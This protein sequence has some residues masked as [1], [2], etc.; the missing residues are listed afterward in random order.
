MVAYLTSRQSLTSSPLALTAF[1]ALLSVFKKVLNLRDIKGVNSAL[2]VNVVAMRMLH[3]RDNAVSMIVPEK[4]LTGE[5][6]RKK[7]YYKVISIKIIL[8]AFNCKKVIP[9]SLKMS[10][11]FFLL[12]KFS[13]SIFSSLKLAQV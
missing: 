12:L 2:L 5:R 7:N 3:T 13:R 9:R 11:I 6:E 8:K 10:P 1:E 4:Y